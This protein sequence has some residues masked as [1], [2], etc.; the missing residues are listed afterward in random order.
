MTGRPERTTLV[1]LIV[2]CA[3][4]MQQ[5]DSTVI[6][7]A[8]PQMARSLHDTPVNLS[9]GITAYLLTVAVFIPASGWTADRFG[10]RTVFVSAIAVFTLGSLWCGL[11]G[12]LWEFTAAR[13]VQGIGGALMVP[14]GRLVVLRSVEK[15]QLIRAMQYITIPGLVA[16]VL[17]PPLGGFITTYSS[18]RWIFYLNLPIGVLGIALALAFM[19]NPRSGERRPFDVVGFA[20]S[21]GGL[22]TLMAGLSAVGRSEANFSAALGLLVAGAVV[23]G[24][25]VAHALR[26][27]QPL[28]D[29]APLRVRTFAI[30]NLMGGTLYRIAIGATPLLWALLFQV[31]LGM[32]AFTSGL[33]VMVCT[34]GDLAMAAFTRQLL[35]RYGF[36]SALLVNGF[37]SAG[38]IL[39]W[40]LLGPGTP[41]VVMIAALLWNGL[42]RALQFTAL[43]TL[44]YADI[45]QPL[46]S[47]A[48]S[49]ASMVQQLSMGTGVALGAVA[50]HLSAAL[51]GA[52]A[53]G[54][55]DF[56]VA[57]GT[58]GALALLSTAQF[59]RLAPHAGADTSG[60]RLNR[61]SYQAR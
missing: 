30:S 59:F 33:L 45:P 11:A 8:L 28:L 43:S 2:S 60:H 32:S 7:T 55:F 53:T 50:L 31:V 15:A 39:V 38:S 1:A 16:P 35:R 57:F 51:R 5:L 44:Q 20:L 3:F 25:A 22:A 56:R 4:F 40:A 29:L 61:P 37:F 26:H 46:M 42:S 48:T 21:G 58:M 12:S 54:A 10:A 23:F 27:P 14:V 49:L 6:A 34:G 9:I 41:A 36:R 18:W 19:Q 17:G 52:A 13:I 24:F 47:R